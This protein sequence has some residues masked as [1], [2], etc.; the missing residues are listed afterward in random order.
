MKRV[1]VWIIAFCAVCSGASDLRLIEA[2]KKSD[3]KAVRQLLAQKAPGE[4]K[5][6]GH[7]NSGQLS[8]TC[9]AHFRARPRLRG[10]LA[11]DPI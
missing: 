5:M 2:V 4:V 6:A 1:T 11:G 8:T 3:A 9:A 7:A 10:P